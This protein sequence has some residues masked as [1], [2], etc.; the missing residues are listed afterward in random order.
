MRVE[1]L[2]DE[3]VG[4]RFNPANP[5]LGILLRRHQDDGNQ[6]RGGIGFQGLTRVESVEPRHPDV[7]E[8]EVRMVARHCLERIVSVGRARDE[9]P[10]S[11]QQGCDETHIPSDI[12]DDQ[13][14]A[15]RGRR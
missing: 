1:R 13:D 5:I 14:A 4:A 3:V 10:I 6:A 7:H 2:G 11:T 8:H 12:I 9:V 15:D